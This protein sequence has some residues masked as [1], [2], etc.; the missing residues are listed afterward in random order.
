MFGVCGTD[1]DDV[2]INMIFVHVME[3][4]IMQ[5]VD[6]TFMAYCRMPT[7]RNRAGAYDSDDDSHC[8]WS[9]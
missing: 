1:R 4:A 7:I 5:I 6:M 8:K 2:L 3:M 9:S